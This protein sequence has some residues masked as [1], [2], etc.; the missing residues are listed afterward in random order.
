MLANSSQI[1]LPQLFIIHQR[2]GFI[3]QYSFV[4]TH[5]PVCLSRQHRA[6]GNVCGRTQFAPTGTKI[7]PAPLFDI[8]PKATST[9]SAPAGHLP[10]Q[11][12]GFLRMPVKIGVPKAPSSRELDRPKAETEGVNAPAYHPACL[13]ATPCRLQRLRAFTERPYRSKR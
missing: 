13:S 6:K 9:S 4:P 2:S 12:E 11:G 8:V 10:L 7:I 5:H 1:A 3:I